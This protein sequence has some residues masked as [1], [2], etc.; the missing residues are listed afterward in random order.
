MKVAGEAAFNEVVSALD[1]K[2]PARHQENMESAEFMLRKRV[3]QDTDQAKKLISE[4]GCK[5]LEP[6]VRQVLEPY[7][8]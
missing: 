7:R 1:V 4:N 5:Q 8:R 6:K 2:S 3:E